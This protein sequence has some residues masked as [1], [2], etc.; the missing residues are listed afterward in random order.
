MRGDGVPDFV[1]NG[2]GNKETSPCVSDRMLAIKPQILLCEFAALTSINEGA[3][4]S[5]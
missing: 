5:A 1:E 4:L 2:E 3:I